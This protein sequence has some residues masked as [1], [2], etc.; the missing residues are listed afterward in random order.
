[1]W[2]MFFLTVF[3]PLCLPRAV[4]TP[5]VPAVDF[6]WPATPWWGS[7]ALWC[8]V[9]ARPIDWAA[10]PSGAAFQGETLAPSTGAVGRCSD[11]QQAQA[12]LC[13]WRPTNSRHAHISPQIAAA[14]MRG[15]TTYFSSHVLLR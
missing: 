5:A 13:D 7:W 6:G 12:P 15:V 9:V 3:F 8:P 2:V 1:V 4:R 11:H 14:P 10:G